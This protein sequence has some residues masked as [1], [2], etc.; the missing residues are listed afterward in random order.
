ME[1]QLET[2]VCKILHEMSD[3]NDDIFNQEHTLQV[4]S[5]KLIPQI[6]GTDRYRI[7][8]SDGEHFLQAMLA[9]QLNDMV[10]SNEI[11]KHSIIV[12]EKL[13]MN[14]VQNK[15]YA[16]RPFSQATLLINQQTPHSPFSSR[17]WSR[18]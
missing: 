11:A 9:T 7:I 12:T 6:N 17:R 13:T 16:T 15:K 5:T 18:S 1:A 8:M 14:V 4:L 2:G 3:P 10:S